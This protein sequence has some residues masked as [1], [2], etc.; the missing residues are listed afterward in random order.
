MQRGPKPVPT[1]LR[2]LQ[3]GRS[4]SAED[5]E[6]KPSQPI[7]IPEPP[8]FLGRYARQ[9]WNRVIEDLYATGIYTN[10]DET[11][12]AAYCMA[13][14]RWR[15]AEEDLAVLAQANPS[16]HG[17]LIK[18]TNGNLIQNPLIGVANQALRNMH[19]LAS[20]FGMSP[21]SRVGL[22]SPGS[23]SVDPLSAKYGVE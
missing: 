11:M 2:L 19:R 16:S 7:E 6:P 22:Q 10:I 17:A 13:Y 18:T 21:S 15:H 8:V 12:L 14:S 1:Q 23:R 9:E 3:G 5:L 20:E 4:Q